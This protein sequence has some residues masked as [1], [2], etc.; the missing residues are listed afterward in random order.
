MEVCTEVFLS[1]KCSALHCGD[2]NRVCACHACLDHLR[3]STKE[4]HCVTAE[5][6][7]VHPWSWRLSLWGYQWGA[8]VSSSG[9]IN[10][11]EMLNPPLS[12]TLLR[13]WH[14]ILDWALGRICW[15]SHHQSSSDQPALKIT[16]GGFTCKSRF[17]GFYLFYWISSCVWIPG[18]LL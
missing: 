1:L 9:T 15:R 10:Q 16:V 14:I 4:V 13:S 3:H 7:G 2:A 5:F 12:R 17:L 8:G 11:F 6:L 18:S